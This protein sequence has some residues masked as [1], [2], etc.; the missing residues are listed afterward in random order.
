MPSLPTLPP[1]A[2]GP[3]RASDL[4]LCERLVRG[5]QLALDGLRRSAFWSG[6]RLRHTDA[7][8]DMAFVSDLQAG[9]E[10]LLLVANDT[11]Q[12]VVLD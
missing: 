10:S 9:D 4:A 7:E 8:R 6:A 11:L 1:G 3:N 12:S 5:G 2:G